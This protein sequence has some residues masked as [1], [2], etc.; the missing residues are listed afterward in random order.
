M[1]PQESKIV[2]SH[3]QQF[4]TIY[5]A[6]SIP[7]TQRDHTP[8]V[9]DY[10]NNQYNQFKVIENS[11]HSQSIYSFVIIMDSPFKVNPSFSSSVVK[12]ITSKGINQIKIPF[13]VHAE[14]KLKFF[15]IAN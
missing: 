15:K 2:A 1:F 4:H 13:Y 9:L 8:Q 6:Q 5:H 12:P 3:K 7:I 11:Q 14:F 10:S